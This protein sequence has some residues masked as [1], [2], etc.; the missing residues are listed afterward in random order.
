MKMSPYWVNSK[1]V[2]IFFGFPAVPFH[3]KSVGY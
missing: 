2:V 3:W 1:N